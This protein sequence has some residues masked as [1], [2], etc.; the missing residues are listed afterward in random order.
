MISFEE[1]YKIVLDQA[2]TL[3][4]EKV[5]MMDALGRVLAEDIIADM[6]MPPFDKAAVD[7]YACRFEDINSPMEVIEIISAGKAPLKQIGRA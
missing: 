5:E 6:D 1:A 3:P 4:V 7:G 2:S